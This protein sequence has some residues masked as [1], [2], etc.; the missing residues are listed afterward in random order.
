MA[1]YLET[2]I[3][4]YESMRESL[5]KHHDGKFVV[6]RGETLHGAYDTFDAAA[7]A[8]IAA[9]GKGPYLIREVQEP[10]AMRMPSSVEF[11]PVHASY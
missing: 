3:A 8:A 1:K 7:R 11:G 2:E 4:A 10:I 6:I 9:Y 5:R